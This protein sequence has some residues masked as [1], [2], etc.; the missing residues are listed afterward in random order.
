MRLR[1]ASSTRYL[2]VRQSVLEGAAENEVTSGGTG[3]LPESAGPLTPL[4][5]ALAAL[6]RPHL[7]VPAFL[8][9]KG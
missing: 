6:L 8:P 1:F 3:I 5:E 4:E 9:S 2:A 7:E